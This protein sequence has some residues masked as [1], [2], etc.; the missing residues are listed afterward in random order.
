MTYH[1]IA[2]NSQ[3]DISNFRCDLLCVNA[4]CLRTN[5]AAHNCSRAMYGSRAVHC[6]FVSLRKPRCNPAE[7]QRY[8]VCTVARS[9]PQIKLIKQNNNDRA[10]RGARM[11]H[12]VPFRPQNTKVIIANDKC[13]LYYSVSIY[14]HCTGCEYQYMLPKK[15]EKKM[16]LQYKAWNWTNNAYRPINRKWI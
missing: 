9:Q 10:K 16:K 12:A 3:G 7:P 13:A 2:N 15:E 11:S 8:R 4:R 1:V 6:A 5:V 14:V